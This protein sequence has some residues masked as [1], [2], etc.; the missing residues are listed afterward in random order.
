M[1]NI[2]KMSSSSDYGMLVVR[3]RYQFVFLLGTWHYGDLPS[4]LPVD[5]AGGRTRM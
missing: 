3:S 2:M 5:C 4:I 1:Q